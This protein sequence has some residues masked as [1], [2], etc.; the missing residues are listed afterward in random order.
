MS[1]AFDFLTSNE[2]SHHHIPP[3]MTAHAYK[4]EIYMYISGTIK[5]KFFPAS[6]FARISMTFVHY[7]F[8]HEICP[9]QP[10]Y[11]SGTSVVEAKIVRGDETNVDVRAFLSFF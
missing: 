8:H 11:R 5:T 7:L 1:D 6:L 9:K 4:H 2:S 3:T 10:L